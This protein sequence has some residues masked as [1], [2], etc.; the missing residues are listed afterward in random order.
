MGC[1]KAGLCHRWTLW[2][3]KQI[4]RQSKLSALPSCLHT[5]GTRSIASRVIQASPSNNLTHI[6]QLAND[7]PNNIS[8]I[9]R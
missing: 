3:Y 1:P 6:S 2:V 7:L 9:N 4:I 8:R 5:S